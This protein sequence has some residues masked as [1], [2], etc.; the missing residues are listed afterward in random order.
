MFVRNMLCVS[1]TLCPEGAPGYS[2][3][4]AP[5]D[6]RVAMAMDP[7]RGGCPEAPRRRRHNDPDRRGGHR[8]TGS[9]PRASFAVPDEDRSWFEA[10]A[11]ASVPLAGIGSVSLF[12]KAFT[13]RSAAAAGEPNECN[14]RLEFLGDSVISAVVSEYIYTRF[15]DQNEGFL[16]DMRS[17]LVR[18]K[19]LAML[20]EKTGLAKGLT[21]KSCA[22]EAC[23]AG[24]AC[25]AGEA[26][27]EHPARRPPRDRGGRGDAQSADEFDPAHEDLF[28]SVVGAMFLD[29]GYYAASAWVL[30]VV[31]R[32]VD[33]SREVRGVV[34]SRTALQREIR[35][36]GISNMEVEVTRLPGGTF[37]SVA[38]CDGAVVG[39]GEAG[40]PKL[41]TERACRSARGYLGIP[42]ARG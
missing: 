3:G 5:T 20:A 40:T 7:S 12:R 24:G 36:L 32:H 10:A 19:T 9:A 25:E 27:G 37:K 21:R 30:G 22:G 6:Q 11:E 13:H 28:E 41:A 17:K 4:Q 42:G 33:V 16:T 8:R 34:S 26:G 35:S 29:S 39:V 18:G 2:W 38:R 31:E 1:R 23:E 14:E 15:P